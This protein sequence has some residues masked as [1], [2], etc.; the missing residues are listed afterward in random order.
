MVNRIWHHLFGVGIIATVDDFGRY[1]E[2]P[3]PADVQLLDHLTTRFVRD[4]WSIKRLIRTVVLS[5]T[6]RIQHRPS[7]AAR[8]LDPR[9]RWLQHYPA[10]VMEAE[11][12]RDALLDVSSRL[13]RQLGG[14]SVEPFRDKQDTELRLF[15]GPLDGKG[16]RSL[17]LKR[18]LMAGDRF[19]EVFNATGGKVTLGRRDVTNV[20][21]QALMLM[22]GPLPRKQAAVWASRLA[23]N[24]DASIADRVERMFRSALG[25][26]PEPDERRRF[27]TAIHQW[28]SDLQSTGDVLKNEAVWTLAAHAFFNLQEFVYIP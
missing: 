1:G 9:N 3:S 11:M 15:S 7:P 6:F 25:R 27:E 13:D 21:A 4:G 2:Q 20:P 19:L 12:V 23:A 26:P 22:N 16:R 18:T 5:R 24:H 28:G 8:Q 14:P 10:R 17:Y